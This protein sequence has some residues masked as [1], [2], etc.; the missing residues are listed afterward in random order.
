[1]QD[2]C[3]ALSTTSFVAPRV[4][5]W[6]GFRRLSHLRLG[7]L[8]LYP[9]PTGH[10]PKAVDYQFRQCTCHGLSLS[11][12]KVTM[13]LLFLLCRC[14][15]LRQKSRSSVCLLLFSFVAPPFPALL[16]A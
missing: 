13:A 5:G 2:K 12:F 14:I 16:R 8:G 15:L 1:M 3:A 10:K 11:G 7:Q 4:V 9:D 6:A